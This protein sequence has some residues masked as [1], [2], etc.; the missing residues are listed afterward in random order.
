MNEDT[1]VVT[2]CPARVNP[3]LRHSQ[4]SR[5]ALDGDWRFRLDPEDRGVSERWFETANQ[6]LETIHVPGC[7]QGQGFGGD[8]NDRLWDFNL[9]ARVYRATYKGTG[10]YGRT[11]CVPSEWAGKWVWLNFGGAHPSAEVWVNGARIGESDLPFVPFAFDITDAV[12]PGADNELVVRVHEHHRE[13][14]FAYNWQGNWSGLY[15]GVEL[16]AT[17][18]CW[19]ERCAVLPEVDAG[20]IRL[21]AAVGGEIGPDARLLVSAAP[22]DGARPAC[23]A[24]FSVSAVADEFSL[25]VPAPLLWSPDAPHLYRVDIELLQGGMVSDARSERTGFVKLEGAGKEFRINGEPYY[26][27]GSGDFLSCPETGCPDTDRARWRRKLQALRDYGYNY[28]RCQSYVYGPEYYDI[29]DEVGLLVQSEM[30]MIGG[31]GG[32]SSMHVY[33][34]PTPTPDN[35]PI[36]KRQWDLVVE[37]DAC[38]P[39]ATLYCMSNEC[40]TNTDFP[41]IAW[42]CYR[43]TKARKPA[44]LVIWTD[45]GYNKDLPADFINQNA[46]AFTP[47]ALA[48]LDKPLIEHEFKW[49]SSFPDVR[50]REKYTGAVRPYAAEIAAVAA[51]RHSQTHLLE[52]YAKNSQRLQFLE[53][54]GKMES[55]RRDRPTLAGICH[56]N[57]MDTNPSPQ[58]ILD[59]FYERKLADAATWR[60]TNGDTVV[61]SSLGFDDRCL[62]AGGRVTVRFSVSDFAHPSWGAARLVWRLQAG[63]R[64]LAKGGHAVAIT[65]F[66][67]APAGEAEMAIPA[68]DVPVA[69][70]VEVELRETGGGRVARNRWSLWLFPEPVPLDGVA[71]YGAARGSWLRDWPALPRVDAL[72]SANTPGAPHVLLAESLDESLLAFMRAGGKVILAAGEGLVRP[73]PPLFGYVNYFFTPPANYAP[74]E[75]GQNGTVVADHPLLA[76][77]PHEGFANLQCFR[78]I[79]N[80]PP[81]DLEPLGLAD[82]APV[83]RVIHRYPVL[84]PLGYLVARR[85]GAGGL[86]MSS[87]AF[88]PAWIEARWLLAALCRRLAAD[89]WHP[90]VEL[91][92]AAAARLQGVPSHG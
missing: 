59:E 89:D 20:A 52:T 15:R 88:N 35:Y 17:G 39:S 81:L 19:L 49:W 11:F 75:D 37:R 40:W 5:L 54:K 50:L 61:L 55:L 36:L 91:S 80:A 30:G 86:L 12:R 27:R 56:F 72:P 51:A 79:D 69:A 42:E 64:T 43:A 8:G 9:E 92:A 38:H 31:W 48:A 23:Q 66:T 45:G 71:V 62:T 22:V 41:R 74:Y 58:G 3:L 67:T 16:S 60:E 25:P 87:L 46:D 18:P 26:L 73:H 63:G 78:M 32:S 65:P 21:R 77:F 28:V 1:P 70:T 76:G 7:W 6:L 53:A 85:V 10:W 33:Q 4:E 47:E 24:E 34:W 83:I 14:G 82:A 13:F 29:A 57:A 90:A 84:R 2:I 68:L 44:A